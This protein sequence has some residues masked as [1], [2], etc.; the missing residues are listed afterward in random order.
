MKNEK[1]CRSRDSSVQACLFWRPSTQRTFVSASAHQLQEA[2]E[3]FPGCASIYPF[4]DDIVLYADSLEE[5]LQKLEDFMLFCEHYNLRLNKSKT[6]LAS[7]AVRHAYSV[8][9]R[10]VTAKF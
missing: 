6:E 5:M 10:A 3:T 8:R 9:G 1:R 7:T 2:L 4:V